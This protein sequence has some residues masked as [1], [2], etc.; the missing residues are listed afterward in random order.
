M[1]LRGDPAPASSE[2]LCQV[3]Q[4]KL[5]W[6]EY[7]ISTSGIRRLGEMRLQ[8]RPTPIRAGPRSPPSFGTLS[9]VACVNTDNPAMKCGRQSKAVA[10]GAKDVLEKTS[11][12]VG[13]GFTFAHVYKLPAPTPVAF[14]A[15]L[16]DMYGQ[17][18]AISWTRPRLDG[19]REIGID[20][21]FRL[22]VTRHRRNFGCY[23]RN[24]EEREYGRARMGSRE[25]KR[26]EK[27]MMAEEKGQGPRR[28]C[29]DKRRRRQ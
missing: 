12:T 13:L 25:A 18:V 1:S 28:Q 23:A 22:E 24:G 7:R 3:L 15:I 20:L 17:T 10:T 16:L 19:L 14:Q 29:N 8:H 26:R 9:A 11:I 21:C 4:R 6:Q 2:S 27:D 5:D